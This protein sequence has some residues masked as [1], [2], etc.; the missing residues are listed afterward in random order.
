LPHTN[1]SSAGT[2]KRSS[3]GRKAAQYF[4][5]L[6]FFWIY[7]TRGVSLGRHVALPF[8]ESKLENKANQPRFRACAHYCVAKTRPWSVPIQTRFN[9]QRVEPKTPAN[10]NWGGFG[11]TVWIG[12]RGSS[13]AA[14]ST[15]CEQTPSGVAFLQS[16]FRFIPLLR[17]HLFRRDWGRP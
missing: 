4:F 5:S 10:E 7:L 2:T 13:S 11:F 9:F 1:S 16:L 14:H 12:G 8:L 3:T 17:L 6:P 15:K